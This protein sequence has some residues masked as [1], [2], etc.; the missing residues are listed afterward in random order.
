VS[1]SVE[2]LSKP[3]IKDM[4]ETSSLIVCIALASFAPLTQ[5]AVA[6]E[7]NTTLPLVYPGQVLYGGLLFDWLTYEV[8]VQILA[9]M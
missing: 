1:C 3:I 5:P 8:N 9:A 4:M 6:Q 7:D 2:L